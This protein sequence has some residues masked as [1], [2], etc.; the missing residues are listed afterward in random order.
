MSRKIK[1]WLI[2]AASLIA[3]GCIIFAGVMVMLEWDFARLSA[4]KHETNEH[5]VTETFTSI[6][7]NTDTAEVVFI[8]SV[9]DTCT[10]TCYELKTVKH[11]VEVV[12]GT[13]VI[14]AVDTRK[15]H[16]YIG[17]TFGTP[18][19]TV[20]IPEGEYGVLTVKSSTGSVTVPQDFTFES[21]DITESTGNID[22][23]ASAKGAVKLE[24]STGG[25]NVSG[26]SAGDIK[27]ITSTGWITVT[28][29][30]CECD[31]RLTVSTGKV[32][33]TNV[34]CQS[35]VSDGSTGDVSLKNVVAS[36]TL[37]VERST[38]DVELDGC[39][40]K[41]LFITTDT[42][43]VEGTLLSDKVFIVQTDTGDIDVPK[44]TVGGRCE[45]TTDTGDVEIKVT[46]K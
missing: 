10:V 22:C 23:R 4:S 35:L 11:S 15:W 5:T 1:I 40:A 7:V 8:P 29:V 34:T 27:L 2:A 28:D 41:E 9:G 42:G 46:R 38:G 6:S 25:I 30:T 14:K 24:A 19:I 32:A 13:L 17:I 45:I 43:D 20:Q 44:T 33:L 39:D 21:I 16:D 31:V 18:K 36:V 12:N 3:V 37:T 26:I